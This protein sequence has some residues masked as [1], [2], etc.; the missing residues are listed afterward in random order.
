MHLMVVSAPD[1]RSE[2]GYWTKWLDDPTAEPARLAYVGS[3]RPKH[4]LAWAVPTCN[5]EDI[6]RI[7]A[8]GFVTLDL[9]QEISARETGGSLE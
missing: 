2:D 1:R 5:D 3:S 7:K 9:N 8:L 4:L 6:A